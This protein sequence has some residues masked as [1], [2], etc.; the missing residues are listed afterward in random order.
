MVTNWYLHVAHTLRGLASC[1]PGY[2]SAVQESGDQLR[3]I[4][5]EVPSWEAFAEGLRLEDVDL[6]QSPV[7]QTMV[8]R[9]LRQ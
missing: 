7:N 4:G 6:S 8:G 9:S 1:S 3:D 2:L 5:V